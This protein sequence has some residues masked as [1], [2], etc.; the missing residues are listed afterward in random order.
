MHLS[1]TSLLRNVLPC[2]CA[3]CGDA[4]SKEVL[5]EACVAHFFQPPKSRCPV[6]AAACSDICGACLATP[7]AFDATIV[8]CDYAAPIDHLVQDL[9][10]HARLALAPMFGRLLSVAAQGQLRAA[11]V[12]T[13]VPLSASRL[14][15]RGFNQALEI[16]KPLA[17]ALGVPL[18]AQLCSRVRDTEAQAGLPLKQRQQNMRGAFAMSLQG[19]AAVLDKHVIV[20]DDV[21]T[22]AH[23]LHELAACLKRHGAARVTNLV[24]ARTPAR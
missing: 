8:A 23:T 6:C 17:R 10:F 13:G 7:P 20:V 1:L 24:F 2:C 16:A 9:K 21:M 5:C 12:M 19:R 3:L 22:T 18:A 11:D 14:A 4:A 15:E